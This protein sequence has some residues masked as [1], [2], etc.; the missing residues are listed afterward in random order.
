MMNLRV[1]QHLDALVMFTRDCGFRELSARDSHQEMGDDASASV[2]R[3]FSQSEASERS[4]MRVPGIACGNSSPGALI[5]H[6]K[7][8]VNFAGAL[9]ELLNSGEDRQRLRCAVSVDR[10]RR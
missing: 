7:Q 9:A 1:V 5:E 10:H 6:R 8:W 4:I 2:G 3:L